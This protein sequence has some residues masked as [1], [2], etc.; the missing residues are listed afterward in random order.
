MSYVLSYG[1]P[2]VSRCVSL[3]LPLAG[4]SGPASA[5]F[6]VASRCVP[7]LLPLAGSSGPASASVPE[8]YGLPLA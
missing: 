3:L 5:S 7:L 6:P 1:L 4:S 8:S 2:V